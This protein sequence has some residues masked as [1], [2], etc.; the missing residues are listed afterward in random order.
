MCVCEHGPLTAPMP[1]RYGRTNVKEVKV[2]VVHDF[3]SDR[4]LVRE[5]QPEATG[6]LWCPSV[7]MTTSQKAGIELKCCQTDVKNSTEEALTE[8]NKKLV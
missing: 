8:S 1:S 3:C 5:G 6:H 4:A 2:Y 7:T